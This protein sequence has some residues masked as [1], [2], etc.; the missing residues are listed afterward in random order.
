MWE[1]QEQTEAPA[2]VIKPS[3]EELEQQLAK[4]ILDFEQ[5]QRN[6][7]YY[8]IRMVDLEYK[9]EKAEEW[10]TE[11]SANGFINE[12][13]TEELCEILGIEPE[14]TKT[15]KWSVEIEVTVSAKRG[16]DF[17][18][19]DESDMEIDVN[20]RSYASGSGDWSIDGV[21]WSGTDIEVL[22]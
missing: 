10:L 11:E 12:R 22:E 13:Q 6:H 9:L 16:F 18:S 15:I 8:R 4:S 3:Y 19:I 7:E 14:I 21:D 1:N 5:L 20:Q 17:E 2:E